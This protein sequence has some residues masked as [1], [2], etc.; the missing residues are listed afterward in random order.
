MQTSRAGNSNRQRAGGDPGVRANGQSSQRST[1]RIRQFPQSMSNEYVEKIWA[2]LKAAIQEI[3]RKN[4]SGL[5]FEELYRNAY[6]MVLHKHGDKLYQGT[7]DAII[8]H[9]I[10]NIRPIIITSTSHANTLQTL[11]ISW[12]DHKTSMTMIR[13]I[14]MYMDRVHVKSNSLDDVQTLGTKLFRD[15]IIKSANIEVKIRTL[16][17]ERVDQYR[18]GEHVEQAFNIKEVCT[19]LMY[20]GCKTKEV[21]EEVFERHFLEKTEL[22]YKEESDRDIEQLSATDYVDKVNRRLEE[23]HKR[24][25]TFLDAVSCKPVKEKIIKVMV[26]K[27]HQES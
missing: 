27:K 7:K 9:L 2:M 5:S 1:M 22:F 10:E 19:M 24:T 6:T 8:S 15:Q 13:D 18:K 21:Y 17:L 4:N 23:E 12:N 16:L 11:L 20:L 14:L 3:Q 26:I 25:K